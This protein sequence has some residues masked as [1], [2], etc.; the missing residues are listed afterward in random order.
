MSGG[1]R[2]N[3]EKYLSARLIQSVGLVIL[4]GAAVFWAWTGRESALLMSAALSLIGIG[5]YKGLV[6]GL[7]GLTNGGT[8][9]NGDTP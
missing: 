9:K 6:D 3:G 8:K 2:R 4:I 1:N 5:T 7:R